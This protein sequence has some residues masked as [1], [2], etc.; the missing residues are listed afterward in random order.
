MTYVTLSRIGFISQILP[1]VVVAPEK[2]YEFI[3]RDSRLTS[4]KKS[5]EDDIIEL[6]VKRTAT[7]TNPYETKIMYAP[8]SKI[9]EQAGCRLGNVSG[10]ITRTSNKPLIF[11][12]ILDQPEKG[13]VPVNG[14]DLFEFTC[15]FLTNEI[16]ADGAAIRTYKHLN[17]QWAADVP[18]L[19]MPGLPLHAKLTFNGTSKTIA[20]TKVAQL[21]SSSSSDGSWTTTILFLGAIVM[22]GVWMYKQQSP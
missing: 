17:P 18:I 15:K 22:L 5:V 16:K 2:V 1:R 14:S 12:C 10:V 9:F 21:P 4:D 7:D 11:E 20:F 19:K 3:S 13:W 8:L 6:R